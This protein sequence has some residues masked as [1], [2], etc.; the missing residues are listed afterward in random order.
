[1][2]R[3][4]NIMDK[5][6]FVRDI[7]ANDNFDAI[8]KVSKILYEK[9]YVKESFIQAIQDREKIFPTGLPTSGFGVAIPHT[10]A[11]HVMKSAVIIAVLNKPVKFVMM[12]S[13][14]EWVEIKM[15]FMMA[16][17]KPHGQLEMLA[18]IIAFIQN[19]EMLKKI[20]ECRNEDD[21][22][23]SMMAFA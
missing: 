21:I 22:K 7:D 12:G 9:G 20:N 14:E 23:Q 16:I 4:E 8:E 13:N 6:L 17:D 15:L 19:E 1:M 5:L 2:E 11:E 10:D 3:F 18:S